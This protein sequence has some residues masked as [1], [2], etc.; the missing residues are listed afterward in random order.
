[1]DKAGVCTNQSAIFL[2]ERGNIDELERN[3]GG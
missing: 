3:G 1:L 2:S